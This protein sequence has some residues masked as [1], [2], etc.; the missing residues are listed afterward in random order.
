MGYHVI[1]LIVRKNTNN[2]KNFCYLRAILGLCKPV[3][4]ALRLA[5]LRRSYHFRPHGVTIR[6]H[7]LGILQRPVEL[8]APR[9]KV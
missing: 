9:F 1:G 7:F 6:L 5:S 4:Y 3:Q 2:A 8:L